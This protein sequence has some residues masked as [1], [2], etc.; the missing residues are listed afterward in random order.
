MTR[1]LVIIFTTTT[2]G[3]AQMVQAAQAG[4]AAVL[5]DSSDVTVRVLHADAARGADLLGCAAV[6]FATPEHLGTMAGPMKTFFD[7]AYYECLGQVTGRPYALMVCAGTDGQ[8]TIRQLQRIA[9]GL[10]L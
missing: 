5:G 7:R 8:G 2:G 1:S 10:K 6:L 4:A 3:T 9:T